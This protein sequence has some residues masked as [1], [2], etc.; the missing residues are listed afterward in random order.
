[1][2]WSV[3]CPPAKNGA[4]RTESVES[5]RFS[6]VE[7]FALFYDGD[8]KGEHTLRGTFAPG[9]WGSVTERL[10]GE[11]F[12]PKCLSEA[13]TPALCADHSEDAA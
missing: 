13:K 7:G 1:M 5:E 11:L 12:C 9:C 8:L 2:I 3:L 6:V 10:D 4:E